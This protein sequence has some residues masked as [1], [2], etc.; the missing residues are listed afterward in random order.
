MRQMSHNQ[1]KHKPPIGDAAASLMPASLS[2]HRST[3]ALQ[4]LGREPEGSWSER[5][6]TRTQQHAAAQAAAPSDASQHQA[7][8]EP[9]TSGII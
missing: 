1:Y 2:L 4:I 5:V 7:E 3:L 6:E 9:H 8:K